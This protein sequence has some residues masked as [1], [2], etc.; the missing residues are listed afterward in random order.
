MNAFK[1]YL[2]VVVG[3]SALLAAAVFTA[4]QWGSLSKFSAFGPEVPTRTIYLVLGSAA[5]GVVV[6]WMA[7]LTVRG[8]LALWE[9]RRQEKR[10]ISKVRREEDRL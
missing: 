9:R 1:A 8:A 2:F 6:F 10:I 5:G 3:G 7:R 4:L